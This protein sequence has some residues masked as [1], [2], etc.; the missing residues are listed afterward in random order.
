[1]GNISAKFAR[2][3]SIPGRW[4]SRSPSPGD[5]FHIGLRRQVY[6]TLLAKF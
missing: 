2:V 3:L 4:R 6:I 5:N 1:M